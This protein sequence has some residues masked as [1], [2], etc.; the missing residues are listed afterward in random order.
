MGWCFAR[1]GCRCAEIDGFMTLML[2]LL[3]LMI[4]LVSDDGAAEG[5]LCFAL[6]GCLL[7]GWVGNAVYVLMCFKQHASKEALEALEV[8]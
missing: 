1:R 2:M 3:M 6:L 8:Q 7:G 4:G 5:V